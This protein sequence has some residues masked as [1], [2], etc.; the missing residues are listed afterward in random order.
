MQVTIDGAPVID[1][2]VCYPG[3]SYEIEWQI[4]LSEESR[5]AIDRENQTVHRPLIEATI[6]LAPPGAA[7]PST[8]WKSQG[9]H[10][11]ALQTYAFLV[12]GRRASGEPMPGSGKTSVIVS[13]PPGEH[14]MSSLSRRGNTFVGRATG[15][16]FPEGAES[17]VLAI[18]CTVA[19]RLDEAETPPTSVCAWHR[20]I[21]VGRAAEP[22]VADPP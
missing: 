20:R 11:G 7:D 22:T 17:I 19:E 9:F 4:T 5:I 6:A 13:D 15:V 1:E 18:V 21:R 16:R 8:L 3:V 10:L 2:T 14:G 12:D